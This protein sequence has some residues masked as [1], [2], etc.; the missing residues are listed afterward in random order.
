MYKNKERKE[1][2]RAKTHFFSRNSVC[3]GKRY[4][5]YEEG[6]DGSE[7]GWDVDGEKHRD[8]VKSVARL[9]PHWAEHH[10]CL[11][12]NALVA[13]KGGGSKIDGLVR[14]PFSKHLN[15]GK[16]LS[17]FFITSACLYRI[18]TKW[19]ENCPN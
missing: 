18:P 3:A 13:W 12:M 9:G 15:R 11:D 14:F 8:I 4:Q 16:K 5:K 6:Y 17:L 19:S 7:E 1:Q 10:I 2:E